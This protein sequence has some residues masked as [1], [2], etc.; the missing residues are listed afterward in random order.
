MRRYG[1]PL[2]SREQNMKAAVVTRV[3]AATGTIA[4]LVA[5]VGAGT[6]WS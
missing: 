5:V 4:V 2:T 1:A 3:L 6:K